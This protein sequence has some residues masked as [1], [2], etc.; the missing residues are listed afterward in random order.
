MLAREARARLAVQQAELMRALAGQATAP[1]GTD[2][3][4]LRTAARSLARKRLRSVAR[5]WPALAEA[6]ADRFGEHFASF[7]A[8][9]SMPSE[10]GPLADGRAFVQFLARRGHLPDAGRLEALAVDLRYARCAGGLRRRRGPAL[11]MARL[12]QPGRLVVAVRLPWFGEKWFALPLRRF[13]A[14][15]LETIRKRGQDSCF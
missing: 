5:A 13:A 9:T 14:C 7:A 15:G 1:E 12:T 10:G 8:V 3:E 4:R 11:K 6:L 2:A